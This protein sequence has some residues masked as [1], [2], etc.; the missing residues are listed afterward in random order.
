MDGGNVKHT[1]QLGSTARVSKLCWSVLTADFFRSF[2]LQRQVQEGTP[3]LAVALVVFAGFAHPERFSALSGNQSVQQQIQGLFDLCGFFRPEALQQPEGV[4]QMLSQQGCSSGGQLKM[5]H[6][7]VMGIGLAGHQPF[8]FQHFEAL[9][10]GSFGD[11]Q[12]FSNGLRCV[13]E[14]VAEVQVM[15]H[16]EVDGMQSCWM[17]AAVLPEQHPQTFNEDG[18]H[19]HTPW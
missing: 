15:H 7:P 2:L 10:K 8:A 11:A 16:L 17:G 13:A 1:E 5:P 19:G 14:A 4:L 3:A 12:I 6:T 18:D 9:G